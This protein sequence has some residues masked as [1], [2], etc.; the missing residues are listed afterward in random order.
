[1]VIA[2]IYS[3][4]ELVVDGSDSNC[5]DIE[6]KSNGDTNESHCAI[7]AAATTSEWNVDMQSSNLS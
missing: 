2:A 3:S 5:A 6:Q 7:P 1:L 4:T